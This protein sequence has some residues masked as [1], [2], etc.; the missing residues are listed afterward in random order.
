M[1]P[2]PFDYSAPEEIEEALA[3]LHE[4]GDDGKVLAGGQSLVPLLALRLARFDML[5]DINRVAGLSGVQRSG[6]ELVIGARTRQAEIARDERIRRDAPLLADATRYIGHF[7]IR[8]RGTIGGAIAHADPTA[9]YPAAALALDAE[10]ELASQRGRRRIAVDDFLVSAYVTAIEPDE[11]VVSVRVPAPAPRAGF[12]IEEIARR[13]GDFALVG[14]VAAV[15]LD[16]DDAI[17]LARVVMFG[18]GPRPVRLTALE[19]E[20]LSCRT[21]PSDLDASSRAVAAGLN[22]PSDVQASAA[23]RRDVSGPLAARLVRNAWARA[24][25]QPTAG[26]SR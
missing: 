17:T 7:Q 22:P 8:N 24:Q 4:H 12:A 20:I 9:E 10:I 6:G 19:E 13:P 16:D 11:L 15:A 2:A 25:V 18:V 23:Y 14:G 1:K 26:T 21:L 3:L 5:I